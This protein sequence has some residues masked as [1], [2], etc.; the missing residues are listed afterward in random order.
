VQFAGALLLGRGVTDT[1]KSGIVDRKVFS[2]SP[3]ILAY[4]MLCALT[5]AS[6]W[7]I[8]ATYLEMPVSTTHSII[9]Y[10]SV[11]SLIGSSNVCS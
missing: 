7:L 6:I 2:D 5:A 8:V 1:I 3:E 4:G 11:H 10:A 9:G